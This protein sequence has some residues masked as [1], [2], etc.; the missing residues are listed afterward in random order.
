M[1]E[2]HTFAKTDILMLRSSISALAPAIGKYSTGKPVLDSLI[3]FGVLGIIT[4]HSGLYVMVVKRRILVGLMDGHTIYKVAEP[5]IFRVSN[6]GSKEAREESDSTP[7]TSTSSKGD[8]ADKVRT[9]F[10]VELSE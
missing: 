1:F 3:A 6:K 4:L 10:V 5:A 9:R 7:N 2:A 8:S